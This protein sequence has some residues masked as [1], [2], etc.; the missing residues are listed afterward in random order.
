M[1][2]TPLT[3]QTA[4]QLSPR[5]PISLVFVFLSTYYPAMYPRLPPFEKR[6]GSFVFSNLRIRSGVS[7]QGQVNFYI[8]RATHGNRRIFPEKEFCRAKS[9]AC[10]VVRCYL[11]SDGSPGACGGCS[12]H[13]YAAA[14]DDGRVRLG[15]ELDPSDGQWNKTQLGKLMTEPSMKPF[16]EDLRAQLQSQWSGT[17]RSAGHPPRRFTRRFDG[18]GFAGAVG[19][20]TR[21]RGHQPALGC[22][23]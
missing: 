5:F 11:R 10:V 9:A 8:S 17:G 12:L 16:E 21:H 14:E 20:D 18:R 23:R 4:F 13:G 1:Y 2:F 7:W 22:H 19:T 3:N 6:Q 15:N